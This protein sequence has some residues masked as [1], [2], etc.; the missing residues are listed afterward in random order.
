VAA[1]RTASGQGG[2]TRLWP[3]QTGRDGTPGSRGLHGV[4]NKASDSRVSDST[5]SDIVPDIVPGVVPGGGDSS[6]DTTAMRARGEGR[7]CKDCVC[8]RAVGR[9]GSPSPA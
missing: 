8:V 2:G 6:I 1:E 4:L 7:V 5:V 9:Y 3:R